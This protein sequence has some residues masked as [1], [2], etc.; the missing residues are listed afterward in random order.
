MAGLLQLVCRYKG[1]SP[2]ADTGVLLRIDWRTMD[3]TDYPDDSRLYFIRWIDRY[4]KPHKGST[5]T[6]VCCYLVSL[7]DDIKDPARATP[8]QIAKLFGYSGQVP[9]VARVLV[10]A[11]PSIRW[12]CLP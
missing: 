3:F 11:L 4:T 9:F 2:G 8:D 1:T 12:I 5:S 7:P 6:S 10:G